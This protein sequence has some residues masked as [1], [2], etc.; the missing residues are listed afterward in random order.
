MRAKAVRHLINLSIVIGG[1]VASVL[2]LTTYLQRTSILKGLTTNPAV[3]D[4][5]AAIF[6]AVLVTQGLCY[7]VL[8][9]PRMTV[10]AQPSAL[11]L[12]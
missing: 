3:R 9:L 1:G 7:I 4:A 5:A 6:P 12:P 2:S 10:L 8:L 11:L